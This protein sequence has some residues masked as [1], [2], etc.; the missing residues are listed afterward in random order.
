MIRLVVA[1][2]AILAAVPAFAL[3]IDRDDFKTYLE[4][5]DALKDERVQKMPEA[6]RIPKIA[7]VNFKMKGDQL[8]RILDKVEAEGGEKGVAQ[9]S[10]EALQGALSATSFK[11]KLKEVKVDTGSPHVVTYI[12]WVADEA[13]VEAEAALLALKAGAADKV[14]STFFLWAVDA[15]GNDLWR[16]KIGADR[17]QRI[18]EDRI[19]DWAKTRYVRLFEIDKDNRG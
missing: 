11:D 3:G 17:T 15:A 5:R 6:Q 2:A 19:A 8:Q 16:A 9:K 10:Q 18:K 14:T 4:T 12:K 1:A 13:N 7:S